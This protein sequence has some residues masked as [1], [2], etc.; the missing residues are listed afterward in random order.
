VNNIFTRGTF[1][2]KKEVITRHQKIDDHKRAVLESDKQKTI[3]GMFK[4]THKTQ[5]LSQLPSSHQKFEESS[6]IILY[7]IF[8]ERY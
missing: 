5:Q 3:D 7:N 1:R 2:Y 8:D 6:K 4:H